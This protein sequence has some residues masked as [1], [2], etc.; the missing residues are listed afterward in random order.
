M[1]ETKTHSTQND[2]RGVYG[3][4]VA[5]DVCVVVCKCV[6]VCIA[7][8]SSR[9]NVSIIFNSLEVITYIYYILHI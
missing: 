6:C 3:A 9:I 7:M 4:A 1:H 5:R 2:R 8:R